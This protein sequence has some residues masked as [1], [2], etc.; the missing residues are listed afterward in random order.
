MS[1]VRHLSL[2]LLMLWATLS[3]AYAYIDGGSAH[4]LIQG[5]IAAAVGALYYLRN[6]KE[7]WNAIKRRWKRDRS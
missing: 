5:L 1:I 6:P 4:L 2:V 7:I 3:P